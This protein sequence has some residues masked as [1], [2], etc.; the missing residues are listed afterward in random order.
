MIAEIGLNALATVLA[1]SIMYVNTN[2]IFGNTVPAW[3]LK[4]VFMQKH[5][6]KVSSISENNNNDI[7]MKITPVKRKSI[8]ANEQMVNCAN[9]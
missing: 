5:K 7:I 9:S 6:R 2:A 3:L 4:F 1:T 8:P